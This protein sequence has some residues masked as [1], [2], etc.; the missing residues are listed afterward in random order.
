MYEDID[1]Y[2]L[3]QKFHMVYIEA[4]VDWDNAGREVSW[5]VKA[6][7]LQVWYPKFPSWLKVEARL[8]TWP[9]ALSL[10]TLIRKQ[11]QGYT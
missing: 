1:N 8:K 5:P 6:L 4:V 10:D 2:Y 9:H 7:T 3:I 11:T